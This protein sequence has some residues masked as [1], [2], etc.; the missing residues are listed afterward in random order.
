VRFRRPAQLVVVAV[1]APVYST[2]LVLIRGNPSISLDPGIFLS[3]A[4]RLAHGDR[5]YV[6]VWD[7]KPPFF[8]YTDAIAFEVAGWRGPFAIDVLWVSAAAIFTWL[9]LATS[10]AST[11]TRVAGLLVYPLLLTGAWYFAGMSELPPLALAPAVAWFW[12]RGNVVAAGLLL[13]VLAFF[14]PDYGLVLAALIV[15]P[16]IAGRPDRSRLRRNFLR[17]S[18]AFAATTAASVAVLQARGEL[19]AYVDT[20]R[21][22]LGYP[23]QALVSAIGERP[24]V[25][26]H[27]MVVVRNLGTDRPRGVLFALVVSALGVVL[28]VGRRGRLHART[29]LGG[30]PRSASRLLIAFVI[31]TGVATVA[32][33]ALTAIWDH[34]LELIA[35]PGT[36]ATCLLV[37]RLDEAVQGRWQRI[38]AISTIAVACS[39]AFGGFALA[40]PHASDARQATAASWWHTPRSPS[41]IALNDE[42]VRMPG[43]RITYARLGTN[44]DDGHAAFTDKRLSLACP[45]FHQYPFSSNLD[46]VLSC[47]RNKRPKLLLVGPSFDPQD[48]RRTRR[49][50]AFVSNGRRL[51]RTGYVQVH[52][53]QVEG[54]KI[55]VWRRSR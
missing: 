49:W 10:N 54:R 52:V 41:A 43:S 23:N 22:N 14:R 13:G 50:D 27:L 48:R 15:A 2:V 18:L 6:D 20:M 29:E 24:G 8:Y 21:A 32:T 16:S 42:A 28:I 17:L 44:R 9:L 30:Q 1:V 55:E 53:A 45:F 11:W 7:N 46:Q 37:S 40:S 38:A 51:L 4:A 35:L 39:V 5:L 36:L 33:L 25:I 19:T 31:G 34:N 12:L 47:L 26:G 3:V